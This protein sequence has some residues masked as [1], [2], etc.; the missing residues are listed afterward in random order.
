M[1][2][3]KILIQNNQQLQQDFTNGIAIKQLLHKRSDLIDSIL[4]DLWQQNKL[5]DT[6]IASL[7]A[8]GGYGRR[9]MHPASD[10]DLLILLNAEPDTQEQALLSDFITTLWDL[11]LEIGQSVRTLDECI[12]EAEKDLTIITNLMES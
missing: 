10:I 4:I 2:L 9:E 1:Q 11:G 3:K 7:V 6:H 8:V 5:A 12:E